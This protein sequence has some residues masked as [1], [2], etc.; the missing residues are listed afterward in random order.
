MLAA[1]L[2]PFVA[3]LIWVHPSFTDQQLEAVTSLVIVVLAATVF[4]VMGTI[5]ETIAFQFGK[6]HTRELVSYVALGMLSLGCGLYLAISDAAN[7]QTVLLVS[8]PHAVLF[9][10][11][12]LRLAHG[13]SRHP[14]YKTALTLGG[15]IEIFLGAVLVSASRFSSHDAATL[16]A[17][18]AVMSIL[19][20]LP[21]VFYWS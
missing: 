18:V 21:L 20:L 9:G 15:I 2:V 11:A 16:L 19:Q 3:L 8:A 7:I 1:L 6:E 13:L 17:Y 5:E 4:V 14:S 12:E 10:L